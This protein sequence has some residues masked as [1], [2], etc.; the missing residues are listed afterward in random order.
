MD[1]RLRGPAALLS[2]VLASCSPAV[3]ATSFVR[4]PP[5]APDHPIRIYRSM[6]PECPVEEIGL[7]SSRQ[8]N[9]LISMDAVL[10]ALR[11]RARE[12]GGDAVVDLAETNEAQGAV[13]TGR[14]VAVD[15]DPVL[16]GTVVRFTDP[17]CRR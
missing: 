5:Q 7:V 3:R 8:R 17:D 1:R 6:K 9:K 2:V 13:A 10:E 12:M 16:S 14:S 4:L 15:R 11:K